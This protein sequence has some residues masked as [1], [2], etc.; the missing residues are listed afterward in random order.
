MHYISSPVFLTY[1]LYNIYNSLSKLYNRSTCYIAYIKVYIFIYLYFS[2]VF[3]LRTPVWFQLPDFVIGLVGQHGIPTGVSIPLIDLAKRIW[4]INRAALDLL[5][6]RKLRKAAK[7]RLARIGKNGE[8]G[9]PVLDK[10]K[11]ERPNV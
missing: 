2:I 11:P 5:L 3:A 4:E 7:I 9:H 10:V 6:G 8:V 1:V